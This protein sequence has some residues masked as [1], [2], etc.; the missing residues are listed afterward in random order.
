MRWV[1]CDSP[2][3]QLK[4]IAFELMNSL[5]YLF[6]TQKRRGACWKHQTFKGPY[7]AWPS[8]LGKRYITFF[9]IIATYT[10]LENILRKYL[11]NCMSTFEEKWKERSEKWEIC[12]TIWPTVSRFNTNKIESTF[13]KLFCN[14]VTNRW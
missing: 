10:V 1:S 12:L 3:I 2:L 9:I 4:W 8:S 14:Y 7:L 13:P 6:I 11:Q 5:Y